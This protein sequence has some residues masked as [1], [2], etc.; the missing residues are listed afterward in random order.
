MNLPSRNH[1]QNYRQEQRNLSYAAV[2]HSTE[3]QDA[4]NGRHGTQLELA[5]KEGISRDVKTFNPFEAY[6]VH[7]KDDDDMEE[8]ELVNDEDGDAETDIPIKDLLNDMEQKYNNDGSLR[9]PKSELI[10]FRAGL[11]AGGNFAIINI[12][13]SQHKVCKDDVVIFNKLKPVDKW[14][15]GSTHTLTADEGQVLLMGNQDMTLVGLPFVNGGEV[16]VMVEEIT[17]DQTVIVF[18]KKRRKHYRR[19]NGFRREVTFL[20]ILDVR[21]PD[22]FQQTTSV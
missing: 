7:E 15:V 12:H 6:E 19:K 4:M 20:R 14:S 2:D 11:P 3:Y 10:A 21:F 18:K 1:T 17:R 8:A 5:R 13:G 22:K 16:D 9:R